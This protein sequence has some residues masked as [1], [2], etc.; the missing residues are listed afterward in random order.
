MTKG[1]VSQLRFGLFA[2]FHPFKGF[3]ELKYEKEGSLWAGLIFMVV[4]YITAIIKILVSGYIHNPSKG[5]PIN[6]LS[7]L[8]T[9][10]A[11]YLLITISNWCLTLLFDG[12]GTMAQIGMGLCYAVIPLIFSNV[13]AT[14][15]S[16][17][18]V[19]EEAMYIETIVTVMAVWSWFLVFSAIMQ[20]NQYSFARTILSAIIT[21]VG[22]VV[23]LFIGLLGFN[24]IQQFLA[25]IQSIYKELAFRT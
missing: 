2:I 17:V 6:I 16:C 19:I 7:I 3:Y 1:I 11:P 20:I 21:I 8:L 22:V 14:V 23:I 12:E 13:I 4:Y 15:L 24:L 18:L 10:I 5:T 25:F 9:V